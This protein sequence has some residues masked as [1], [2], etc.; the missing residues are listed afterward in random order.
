MAGLSL[1]EPTMPEPKTFWDFATS[2]AFQWIVL[3]IGLLGTVFGVITWLDGKKKEREYKFLLEAAG[4]NI[5][6]SI[7]EEQIKAGKSEAARVSEQIEQLRK[8]IE[9]E[10]PLEAKRT[11]L[12]DRIDANILTLQETLSATLDLKNQPTVLGAPTDLPR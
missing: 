5:D 3:V 2:A 12:K 1:S 10:I 11:V 9:T 6:K 7:T 8:R 4:K